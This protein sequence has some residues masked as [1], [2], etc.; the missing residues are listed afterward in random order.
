MTL[1]NVDLPHPDGPMTAMNS[2]ALR[3][4]YVIDG[5]ERPFRRIEM[6]HDVIDDKDPVVGPRAAGTSSV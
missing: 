6:F 4:R 1:N 5:R 3:Q 2:P